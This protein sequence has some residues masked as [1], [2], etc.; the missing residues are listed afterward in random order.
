MEKMEGR[1]DFTRVAPGAIQAM[2]GLERYVAQSGLDPVLMNLLKLRTSQI[3]GCAYCID[4]HWKDLRAQGQTE[5]RLYGL[6]AWRESPYY[7]DRERAALAWA[8]AVT[9]VKDGHVPNEIFETVREHFTD[10]ELIS[11][12]LGLVAINGWNRLCIPFR[13]PAGNYQPGKR[14]EVVPQRRMAEAHASH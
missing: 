5:Q 10:E 12:T 14:P 6:D 1:I 13:A 11:L 2:Q 7:T 9:N 4:M 3:N 8:E